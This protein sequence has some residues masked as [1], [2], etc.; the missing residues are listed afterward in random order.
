MKKLLGLILITV[1][2]LFGLAAC[3]NGSPNGDVGG[4]RT[5]FCAGEGEVQATLSLE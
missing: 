2:A 5:L 3:T 1:M 4:L